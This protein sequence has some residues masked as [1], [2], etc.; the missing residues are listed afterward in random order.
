MAGRNR[1]MMDYAQ[2]MMHPTSGA[3]DPKA[4]KSFEDSLSNLLSAKSDISQEQV[5][6]LMNETTWLNAN[7]CLEKGFATEIEKASNVNK[8]RLSTQNVD[9]FLREANLITNKLINNKNKKGMLKV[10]NKLGLVDDANEE[11]ILKAIQEIENK[12]ALVVSGLTD[13]ITEV[14]NQ[15]QAKQ[16]EVDNKQAEIDALKVTNLEAVA[17]NCKAMVNSFVTAG[18]LA[19]DET[20]INKWTDLAVN[21]FDGTKD[22]L[23]GLPVN[24]VANKVVTEEGHREPQ[25]GDYMAEKLKE[26][27]NKNKK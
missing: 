24:R 17:T 21:D 7:E 18:K 23:D 16:T 11:S 22:L 26:I 5:T 3:D 6:E 14:K 27:A 9:N 10:C 12:G 19:N 13:Q 25:V 8:K 2:F 15:L 20:V 4:K 1:V